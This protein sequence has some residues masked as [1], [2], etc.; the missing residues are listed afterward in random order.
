M[1]LEDL[2]RLFPIT[3]RKH[4]PQYAQWYRQEEL[5]LRDALKDCHI[6][7]INH[8]GSTAVEG[9][10]AKPTIDILLELNP[11]DFDAAASIL[12][13]QGWLIMA[14]DNSEHT[15]DLNKGYT[16]QGFAEKVYHLHIKPAGDWDELYFRDYLRSRTEVA[17]AYEQLKIRL[18]KEFEYNRDAYT[19]AKSEFIRIHTQAAR[20][21]F[22]NRYRY[23]SPTS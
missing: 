2:W 17:R 11:D 18:M 6:H 20:A 14:R 23:S 12:I 13:P 19:A 5:A 16:P 7:R 3:L 8:I 21:E 22:G 4:N 10:I 9:L 15:L 1:S